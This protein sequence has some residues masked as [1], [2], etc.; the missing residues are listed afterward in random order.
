MSTEAAYSSGKHVDR[1]MLVSHRGRVLSTTTTSDAVGR[2]LRLG[3]FGLITDNGQYISPLF[4]S[5]LIF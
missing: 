1:D 5:Y 2:C 4:P 3:T